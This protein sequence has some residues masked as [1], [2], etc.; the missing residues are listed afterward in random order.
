M[1]GQRHEAL[2]IN[3]LESGKARALKEGGCAAP[4][5]ALE[6]AGQPLLPNF[7]EK[8]KIP[9]VKKILIENKTQL[10]TSFQTL[11][12]KEHAFFPP[13]DTY[14]PYGHSTYGEMLAA[15][16]NL[17]HKTGSSWPSSAIIAKTYLICIAGSWLVHTPDRFVVKAM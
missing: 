7:Q 17:G 3:K 2:E 14:A 6:G 9:L 15:T 8:L 1:S 16:C 12:W 13:T 11:A 4:R 10:Q 5:N